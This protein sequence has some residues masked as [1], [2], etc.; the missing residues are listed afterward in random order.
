M[1]SHDHF[2]GEDHQCA[3]GR[4][5]MDERLAFEKKLQAEL[6][7][8][9]AMVFVGIG[10][11]L[12]AFLAMAVMPWILDYMQDEGIIKPKIQLGQFGPVHFGPGN[13]PYIPQPGQQLDPAPQQYAAQATQYAAPAQ[14]PESRFGSPRN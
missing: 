9:P 11:A 7:G 3:S 12:A 6:P 14:S 8:N 1:A 5:V 13:R 10:F 2:D 4:L